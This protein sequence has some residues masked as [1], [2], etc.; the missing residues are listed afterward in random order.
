MTQSRAV[1][2]VIKEP[3]LNQMEPGS[4]LYLL[5]DERNPSLKSGLDTCVRS[6]MATITSPIAGTNHQ[7]Q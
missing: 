7:K 2:Q 1:G 4:T 6:R 3:S 5:N